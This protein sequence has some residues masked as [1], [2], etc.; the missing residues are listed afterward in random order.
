MLDQPTLNIEHTDDP[1]IALQWLQAMPDL[2]ACDFETSSIY[3]PEEQIEFKAQLKE[4]DLNPDANH[5]LVID[6][7]KKLNNS[8]LSHPS[9]AIITH[10]SIATSATDAKVI[11]FATDT[12]EKTV[13]DWLTTTQV[14]QVWHN[15]SFD[16]KLIHHR[17]G[18]FPQ[19]FEDTQQLAKA[20]INHVDVY[21]AKVGLKDLMSYRY[22]LWGISADNFNFTQAYDPHVIEYSGIDACATYQLWVDLQ[23]EIQ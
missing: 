6:L 20:L 15:L 16:G 13:L 8:G 3:T 2:V 1:T 10:F 19:N 5:D 22:G 18:K 14:K 12:V 4:A 9:Q 17:T 7:R 23:E 21:K 11:I